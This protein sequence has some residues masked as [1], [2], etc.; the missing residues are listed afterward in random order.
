LYT[1]ETPDVFVQFCTDVLPVFDDSRWLRSGEQKMDKNKI[2]IARERLT[3]ERDV[4]L[5]SLQR[6]QLAAEEIKIE[7]TEDEDDLAS[8]SHDRDVL[9]NLHEGGFARLQLIRKAI[10]AIDGCQYGKC[11]RCEETISDKR[12]DAVPWAARKNPKQ[13]AQLRT[14][15]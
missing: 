4:L 11:I 8:M 9:Y 1:L 12:L 2:T 7:K 10:E 13:N 15:R 3:N 6:S 5:N 14:C